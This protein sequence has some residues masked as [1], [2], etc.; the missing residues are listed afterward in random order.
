M[1]DKIAAGGTTNIPTDAGGSRD[2]ETELEPYVAD[3]V[4][5]TKTSNWFGNLISYYVCFVLMFY[6]SPWFFMFAFFGDWE[7][8]I[9]S[10]QS[11]VEVFGAP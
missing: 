10:L 8:G 1:S 2:G 9:E 3:P 5:E 4:D 7:T 6:L 11:L